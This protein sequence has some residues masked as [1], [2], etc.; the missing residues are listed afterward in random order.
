MRLAKNKF[1]FDEE[2]NLPEN[3]YLFYKTKSF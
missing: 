2:C 3:E 1:A